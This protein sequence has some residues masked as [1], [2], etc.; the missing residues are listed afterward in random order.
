MRLHEHY[1]TAAVPA[2]QA[3]FGY[4]NPL[5]VPRLEKIVLNIGAGKAIQDA[6]YL[7][8]MEQTLRRITG[9]IPQKTKAKKS[10]AAFKIR[11]GMVVGLKVTLRGRR[12]WDFLEKLITV[13]LPRVRDFRGVNPKSFDGQGNYSLGLREALAFPEMSA[14]EVERVHG[15]EMTIATSAR[16]DAEARE[17]LAA[18][19]MPFATTR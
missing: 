3:K 4:R 1:T 6:K 18:L 7:E 8:V 19:G 15:L 11:T 17:L 9:Q 12:M 10:I 2:L 16:T 14:D 13:A 5:M